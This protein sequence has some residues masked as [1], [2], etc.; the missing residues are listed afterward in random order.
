LFGE[1]HPTEPLLLHDEFD[2]YRCLLQFQ[3][4]SSAHRAELNEYFRYV[5][6]Q[7]HV[8]EIEPGWLASSVQGQAASPRD[9]TTGE[10][11]QDA[12][13]RA[14][15]VGRI[16]QAQQQILMLDDHPPWEVGRLQS[17]A[18]ALSHLAGALG[19]ASAAAEIEAVS[20]GDVESASL[21]LG[22]LEA[23]RD[24]LLAAGRVNSP[25]PC[26]DVPDA[27]ATA[28][29]AAPALLWDKNTPQPPVE[30][31]I[32]FGR[33][34]EDQLAVARSLKVDQVKIDRL[35]SLIGELAV[36]KNALPFL[37]QR[38]ELHYG[39]RELSR[40]IKGQYSTINRIADEMQDAI[41]QVRLLAVSFVFQRFPRLVRDLSRKLGKEVRLVLE[42][43]TRKRTKTS[44]SRL[45]TR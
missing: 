11:L 20:A 7:V 12:E 39:V 34:T 5:P 19:V 22:W 44:S 33:R 41:M 4:L 1:E 15:A 23:S 28:G 31:S 36:E 2:T 30:D 18:S 35:M 42:G 40:E 6:D 43:R 14:A 45:P 27:V 38:A 32:K 13:E 9:R 26:E 16:L 8:I 24:R 10:P 21:M 29:G 17:V 3:L 25:K 37:A